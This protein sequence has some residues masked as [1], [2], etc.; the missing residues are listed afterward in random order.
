MKLFGSD[1]NDN[2]TNKDPNII[3]CPKCGSKSITIGKRGYTI[4]FGYL[5]AHQMCYKCQDC[6][7]VW[8]IKKDKKK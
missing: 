3:I 7:K 5:L 2:N 8:A 4:A 1:K 6:G